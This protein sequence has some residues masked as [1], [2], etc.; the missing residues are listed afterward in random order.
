MAI[1]TQEAKRYRAMLPRS[2]GILAEVRRSDHGTKGHPVKRRDL[3]DYDGWSSVDSSFDLRRCIQP[4]PI[5]LMIDLLREVLKLR[6]WNA[7]AWVSHCLADNDH[8]VAAKAFNVGKDQ[9][10]TAAERQRGSWPLPSR[11]T[12]L[13]R[14]S[15]SGNVSRLFCAKAVRRTKSRR[16]WAPTLL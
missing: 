14:R 9:M 6:L 5:E 10:R 13:G 7:L 15:G 3:V 2:Q 11:H 12:S 16:R 8:E 1:I 4:R